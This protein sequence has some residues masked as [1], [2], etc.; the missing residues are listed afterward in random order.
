MCDPVSWIGRRV[1]VRETKDKIEIELD[2]RHRNGVADGVHR[3]ISLHVYCAWMQAIHFGNPRRQRFEMHALDREQFARHGPDMFL[4]SR[5]DAVAPLARLLIQVLPTGERAPGQK[6]IFDEG[7]RTFHAR[8]TVGIADLVRHEAESEAF[9]EGL[10]F[11][12]GDHLSSAAATFGIPA[13]RRH[14]G[15]YLLAGLAGTNGGRSHTVSSGPLA[16]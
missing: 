4:V 9:R 8:R 13:S 12:H 1:E 10:H 14:A 16:W 5:V 2:A 7:K 6:V 11:G 15:G 3:D